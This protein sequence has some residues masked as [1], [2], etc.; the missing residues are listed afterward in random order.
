[1][2]ASTT[3]P[4]ITTIYQLKHALFKALPQDSYVQHEALS[5]ATYYNAFMEEDGFHTKMNKYT[6]YYTVVGKLISRKN[7]VQ[8]EFPNTKINN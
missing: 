4:R 2:L 1:M 7:F 6:V 5:A 3:W 8:P